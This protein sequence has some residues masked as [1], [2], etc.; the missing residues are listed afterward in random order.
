MAAPRLVL[1]LASRTFFLFD[2]IFSDCD[3]F[4]V[5]PYQEGGPSE[6][7]VRVSETE[8]EERQPVSIAICSRS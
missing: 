2:R 1:E 7:S 4:P 5:E 6:N 3:R 8:R